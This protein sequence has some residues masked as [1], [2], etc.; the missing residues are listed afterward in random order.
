M[1][2]FATETGMMQDPHERIHRAREFLEDVDW[3]AVETGMAL[4]SV[5]AA[6]LRR[7]PWLLVGAG[8]GLAAIGAWFVWEDDHKTWA[9]NRVKESKGSEAPRFNPDY[10]PAP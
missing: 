5:T 10:T 9:P 3:E 7:H 6:F 8:A 4:G 1:A 2:H